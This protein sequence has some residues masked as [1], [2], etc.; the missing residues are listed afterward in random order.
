MMADRY[1][2]QSFLHLCGVAQSPQCRYCLEQCEPV[3]HVTTVTIC[4]RFREAHTAGHNQVRAKLTSLLLL[5]LPKQQ[6]KLFEET[7]MRRTELELQHV[8]V[9]CMMAAERL[10]QGYQGESVSVENLQPDIV[11]V[12]QFLKKIGLLDLCIHSWSPTTL[13]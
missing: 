8:L 12:S 5:C 1:P 9:A 4:P 11:P 2:V 3:A 6:W 13:G 10:P 7:P